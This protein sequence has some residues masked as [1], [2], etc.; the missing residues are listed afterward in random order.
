FIQALPVAIALSLSPL[1]LAARSQPYDGC[2]ATTPTG[3]T[4]DLGRLCPNSGTPF[5]PAENLPPTAPPI[6][7]NS[8]SA[9][10]EGQCA[11]MLAVLDAV[12]SANNQIDDSTDEAVAF[13]QAAS[14]IETSA[15]DLTSLRLGDSTLRNYQSQLVQWYGQGAK[16][17]RDYARAHEADNLPAAEAAMQDLFTAG[18]QLDL[19]TQELNSYCSSGG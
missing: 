10:L 5:V 15:R 13:A 14:N 9:G 11:R 6:P 18:F 8:P 7:S 3:E 12:E 1:S 19:L 2:Y 16:S 4:I 17:L